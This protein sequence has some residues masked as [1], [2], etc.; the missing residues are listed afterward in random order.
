M[1]SVSP[2]Q[3]MCICHRSS[4]PSSKD[5]DAFH[6]KGC[7]SQA[8]NSTGRYQKTDKSFPLALCPP[9]PGIIQSRCHLKLIYWPLKIFFLKSYNVTPCGWPPG[10][11]ENR[12][13]N[14]AIWPGT[15][16]PFPSHEWSLWAQ[17]PCQGLTI[18]CTTCSSHRAKGSL[19]SPQLLPQNTIIFGKDECRRC[20]QG[21]LLHSEGHR[22]THCSENSE[23]RQTSLWKW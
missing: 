11:P 18:H 20:S 9:H 1:I 4:S 2:Q 7:C 23:S 17:A 8:T 15:E 3:R 12:K 21:L 13:A 16:I 10:C 19:A 22:C 5:Q 6:L 14:S